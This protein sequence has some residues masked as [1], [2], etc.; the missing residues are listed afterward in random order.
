[1]KEFWRPTFLSKVNFYFAK[2]FLPINYR[3][4]YHY[5]G[6]ILAT[7]SRNAVA[8]E[9]IEDSYKIKPGTRNKQNVGAPGCLE[10][11][12]LLQKMLFEMKEAC[13]SLFKL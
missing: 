8:I 1:M 11:R 3:K 4:T 7:K 13:K 5:P 2:L 10:A 6:T 9:Y 12:Y